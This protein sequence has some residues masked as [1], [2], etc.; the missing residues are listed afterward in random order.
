[1]KVPFLDLR[2]SDKN[3]R[4]KLLHSVK[5]VLISGK[6]LNGKDSMIFEKKFAR[7]IGCKYALGVSS[8]SS[9]L[10]SKRAHSSIFAPFRCIQLNFL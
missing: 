9:A 8:G 1:M 10:F 7:E 4:K 6:I 3:L 2:V 5:K